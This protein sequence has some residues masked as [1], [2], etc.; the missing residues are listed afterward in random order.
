MLSLLIL[1]L[2]LVTVDV[3]LDYMHQLASH[4]KYADAV[5]E[6]GVRS[7]RKDKFRKA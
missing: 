5:R 2:M 6:A 4:M 7:S 1:K 3:T